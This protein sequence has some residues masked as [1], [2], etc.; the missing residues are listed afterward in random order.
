MNTYQKQDIPLGTIEIAP[1]V[2]ER[3]ASIAASHVEG[4]K[5]EQGFIASV[6]SLLVR[7]QYV[8][9]AVLTEDEKGYAI[10]IYGSVVYGH[11]VPKL[12]LAIQEKVRE[13]LLFSC[14]LEIN[15]VNVH[16]R[17]IIPVKT[18]AEDEE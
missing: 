5:V 17:S 13:Q 7:Q 2:I 10:D 15:E 12:A 3:I 9:G 14:E 6:N 8:T 11:S 18:E 1:E 16:V 4:F